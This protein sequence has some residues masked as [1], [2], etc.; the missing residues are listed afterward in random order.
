MKKLLNIE[1]LNKEYYIYDD[2]KIFDVANNRFKKQLPYKKG[3]LKVSFY[4]NGKEKRF[5]VHRLVLMTFNPV[6]GMDKLQVNHI[7]GNKTNNNLSNLEWCTQSENQKHAFKM[8]LVS[9]QG[10]KNSQCRLTEE[11]VIDIANMLMNGKSGNYIH[12]IYPD[13]SKATI[14]AIRSKRLWKH[15]LKDYN[16]PESKYKNHLAKT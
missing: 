13:I 16:F 15:L 12:N 7:D 1:G 9:R 2:G 5:Y 3:Y 4:I 11:Q 6:E 8:G 14:Y 10:T